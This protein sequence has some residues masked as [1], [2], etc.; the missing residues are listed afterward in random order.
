MSIAAAVE[1]ATAL[2]TQRAA[3]EARVT[4]QGEWDWDPCSGKDPPAF[5]ALSKSEGNT[6]KHSNVRAQ[7]VGPGAA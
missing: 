4:K 7:G 2:G 5:E 6:E 1:L 3:V